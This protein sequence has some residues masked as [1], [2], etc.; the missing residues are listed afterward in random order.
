VGQLARF[1]CVGVANTVLSYVV[2]AVLVSAGC[3]YLPAGAVAFAAGAVNGYRLNRRW[4]FRSTDSAARRIRYLAVQLGGLGA[5][6]GLLWLFVSVAGSHHFVGYALTIPAVTL[7][8][9]AANRGWT[10]AAPHHATRREPAGTRGKEERVMHELWLGNPWRILVVANETVTSGLLHEAIALRAD[11]LPAQVLVVAPV[12]ERR[13]RRQLPEDDGA[14]QAVEARLRECLARLNADGIE[15]NG[16]VGAADPMHAIADA[17][18]L[19]PAD[20]IIVATNPENRSNRL[21]RSLVPSARARFRIP[22]LHVVVGCEAGV[23]GDGAPEAPIA[24]AA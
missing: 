15:A 23:V 5:T 21:A 1:A 8:T 11:E 4:T 10:F 20:E 9:F 14:R 17:L 12:L 13:A 6:T 18:R 24:T 19:F 3:P 16:H 22:V 7:T 2:Y